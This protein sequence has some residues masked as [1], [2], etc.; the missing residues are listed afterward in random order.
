M[1]NVA[2]AQLPPDPASVP[3]AR[4]LVHEVTSHLPRRARE[5][6]ELVASELATNSVVHAGTPFEVFAAADDDAV[7]V[8]VA[9][10]TGWS[11]TAAQDGEGGHGLLLVGLLATDWAAQL[12]GGGKRV[13]A[14]L[15]VEDVP[16][17]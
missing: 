11:P 16:A 9:D 8:V 1:F 13:W 2:S 3:A 7:E 4:E 12:E 5:A 17:W 10:G 6:A 14:R 15:A